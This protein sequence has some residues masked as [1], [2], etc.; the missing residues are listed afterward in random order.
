MALSA[1]ESA[2]LPHT[3]S[4]YLL[5]TP[6]ITPRPSYADLRIDTSA[7][8]LEIGEVQDISPLPPSSPPSHWQS[9]TSDVNSVLS[10]TLERMVMDPEEYES[11]GED[12]DHDENG[13][14]TIS[15]EVCTGMQIKWVAGSVWDTYAYQ[16]HENGHGLDWT[17]AGFDGD[18]WIRLRSNE[19]SLILE[20]EQE[21]NVRSCANCQALIQSV[22]LRNFMERAK[23][24]TL[25]PHTPW[26]YLSVLQLRQVVIEA[27]KQ[28]KKYQL[29]VN[30]QMHNII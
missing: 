21:L 10:R 15:E 6:T 5:T 17:P 22:K 24:E 23:K 29:Q 28:V 8:N 9:P 16:Q 19:C 2:N 25:P 11:D 7:I 18:N 3:A 13:Y 12:I 14:A 4:A 1:A 27:R 20:G 26:E 30:F